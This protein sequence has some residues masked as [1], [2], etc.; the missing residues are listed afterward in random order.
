MENGQSNGY[1]VRYSV[2]YPEGARNR[3]SA[4]FRIILVIPILAVIALVSG[5]TSSGDL[6]A[7]EIM[8]PF[9]AGGVVWTATLLML[10]FR[11]KYPRWWFNWNLELQRFTARV[12]AFLFVLRDEYPSTDEEQAVH[13]DI[14]YPN[15]QE[16]LNRF[17]PIIKWALAIPHYVALIILGVLA[18]IATVAAWLSILVTGMYPRG[19]FEFVVGVGRWSYRVTAYAF[20]L[21]TDR[22]PPFRLGD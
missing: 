12:G 2:D 6:E 8:S 14:P 9:F 21:T 1:P 19:L 7:D 16:D 18:L 22:Y 13:L 20:L 17:L 11:K 5:Y 4:L 10:L 3:L 15:A